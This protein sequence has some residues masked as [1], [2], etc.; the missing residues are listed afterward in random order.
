MAAQIRRSARTV[1]GSF[2][3]HE[4]YYYTSKNAIISLLLFFL[5]LRVDDEGNTGS[6]MVHDD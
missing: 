4:K 3:S 6:N 1:S 2:P 5:S